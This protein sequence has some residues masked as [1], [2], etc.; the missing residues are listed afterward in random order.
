MLIPFLLT[1]IFFVWG[2]RLFVLS[3]NPPPDAMLI[4]ADRPPM[5]VEVPAPGRAVRDQRPSRAD[6]P[7]GDDPDDQRRTSSTRST[8]RRCASR[9]TALPGRY[10]ELWFKADKPGT[11]H[12]F[13]SE[14]CGTDHSMMDGTL[15]ILSPADYQDWLTHSGAQQSTVAAGEALF[16][17]PTAA[18]AAT[19]TAR[20][21]GRPRSP[22][23]TAMPV[24]LADGRHDRGRRR[25]TSA[26]RSCNPTATGS[27]ATSRSCRASRA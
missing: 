8:C 14:Y 11:F 10:T 6:G 15:T 26:R 22:A 17:V 27:P 24:P 1:L 2:A 3:K 5:D 23:C 7:A 16:T 9:W 25:T 12:L 4:E 13:C 18:A 20:P 21:C 19:T